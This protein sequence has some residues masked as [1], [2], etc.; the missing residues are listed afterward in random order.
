VAEE[1]AIVLVEP[2]LHQSSI[3]F[4]SF[5]HPT[6]ISHRVIKVYYNYYY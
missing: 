4:P 6:S 2:A 3:I 1:F 5:V